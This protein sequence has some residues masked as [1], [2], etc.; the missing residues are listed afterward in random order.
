MAAGGFVAA[1]RQYRNVVHRGNHEEGEEESKF[2]VEE[3]KKR[4]IEEYVQYI[5]KN[6]EFF[7]NE[8]PD[9]L[10]SELAGYFEEKGQKFTMSDDKYKIK[11]AVLVEGLDP[12]EMNIKILKAAHDKFCVEFNRTGGDQLEFFKQYNVIKEMFDDIIVA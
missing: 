9:I 6:T 12:I 10:L 4:E 3:V 5:Q 2:E 7:S 11:A 1:R 8:N